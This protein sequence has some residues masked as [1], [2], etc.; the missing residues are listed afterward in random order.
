LRAAQ[1]PGNQRANKIT[2]DGQDD[3]PAK[4]LRD[5]KRNDVCDAVLKTT[6]DK[7]RDSKQNAEL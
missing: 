2:N 5:P 1:I 3:C 4:S 6:K 7:E